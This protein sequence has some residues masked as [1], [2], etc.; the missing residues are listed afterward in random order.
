[1]SS[2]ALKLRVGAVVSLALV[3]LLGLLAVTGPLAF[4]SGKRV[5][6]DFAYAGPI[7]KGGAIRISGM[8]VGAV[9]DVEFLGGADPEAGEDVMV[10]VHA[11]IDEKAERVVTDR[12]RF[13]V[14]T[15]GVLGEHYLDI[16][17]QPGG[18]PLADGARVRGV[19][20]ARSDLLLPRAAGLLE[21]M[22]ELLD[23]GRPDAMALVRHV[24]TLIARLESVLGKEGDPVLLA[25]IGAAARDAREVLAALREALGDG[26]SLSRSL[27]RADQT[28]GETTVLLRTLN[29]AD[30]GNAI[31]EGRAT[32]SQADKT[33]AKVDDSLL[34]DGKRQA[35]LARTFEKTFFALE[36]VSKAATRLLLQLEK[37]EGA[38]GEAFQDD[39]LVRDLKAVLRQLSTNPAGLLLPKRPQS[40]AQ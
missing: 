37:G 29:E 38:M 20:L 18:T 2:T 30:L 4:F 33:L 39:A 19:D 35:E 1:M 14:T 15:L 26:Q 23:E 34:V 22:R 28:L 3:V 12:A 10:R 5:R 36:D 6:V 11:R 27:A 16:E 25:D 31:A 21:L 9:E 8:V 24:S 17:P 40:G 13:Y 32:L 7:K